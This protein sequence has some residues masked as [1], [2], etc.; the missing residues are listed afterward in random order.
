MHAVQVSR[1]E[2]PVPRPIDQRQRLDAP[3]RTASWR[4][5]TGSLTLQPF[6]GLLLNDRDCPLEQFMS[7]LTNDS[8]QSGS[9]YRSSTWS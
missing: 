7:P 8:V 3:A 6:E 9:D 4:E 5:A 1:V 2:T